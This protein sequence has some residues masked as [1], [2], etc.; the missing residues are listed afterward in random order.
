MRF[1]GS[2][3]GAGVA[4]WL[5][6]AMPAHRVYVEAFLGRGIVLKTKKPAAASIGIDYDAGVIDS[7]WRRPEQPGL[8]IVHGDALQ[9]LG[10]LRV[11]SDWL[12]Y[13]DPPYLGSAR[14]CQRNYYRKELFTESAHDRLL[15]T[16]TCLDGMVMISGFRSELYCRRLA[17]WRMET[18]WTVNRRGKR[19]EECLWCNFP[20][21]TVRH[22]SSY[23]GNDFTDRQRIKRKVSRWSAKFLAMGSAERQAVLESLKAIR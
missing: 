9:L 1:V 14:S 2:K 23:A 17:S 11:E 3:G 6:S 15:S 18:F 16:L 12:I 19:V 22:D 5:I 20:A 4:P 10:S 13:A 7:Y 21:P 8:A